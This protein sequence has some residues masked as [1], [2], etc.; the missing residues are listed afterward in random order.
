MVSA[1]RVCRETEYLPY[2]FY[3]SLHSNNTLNSRQ[4]NHRASE[5]R[6]RKHQR[7]LSLFTAVKNLFLVYFTHW[8]RIKF[9]VPRAHTG[10]TSESNGNSPTN[11]HS[12]ISQN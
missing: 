11:K 4:K 6:K 9:H 12:I 10:N 5:Q 2:E 8:L 7:K 1:R 3:S